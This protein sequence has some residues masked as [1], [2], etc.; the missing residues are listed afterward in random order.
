[1]S[2]LTSNFFF[3][4][5]QNNEIEA[6]AKKNK[7]TLFF[8]TIFIIIAKGRLTRNLFLDLK[9]ANLDLNKISNPHLLKQMI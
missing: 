9:I 3:S 5:C 4:A 8:V 7:I 6:K 1:L 2:I